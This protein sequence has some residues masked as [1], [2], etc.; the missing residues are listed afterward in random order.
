MR[1]SNWQA[2]LAI[3]FLVVWVT[4]AN[5]QSV[6]T[7]GAYLKAAS[8]EI[9]VVDSEDGVEVFVQD[10]GELRPVA[11]VETPYDVGMAVARAYPREKPF[12]PISLPM[13]GNKFRI[14]SP[15]VYD[16]EIIAIVDGFLKTEFLEGV[17]VGEVDSPIN[18]DP[19]PIDATTVA[20]WVT[21]VNDPSQAAIY[22]AELRKVNFDGDLATLKRRVREA[23]IAAFARPFVGQWRTQFFLP[24][25]SAMSAV[26]SSADYR[27]A[28][29]IVMDELAKVAANRIQSTGSAPIPQMMPVRRCDAF[30]NCTTVWVPIR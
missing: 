7:S 17:E 6:V 3:F 2:L 26:G 1:A 22:L 5:G 12:P 28:W 24:L 16:V 23:R 4:I 21:N 11:V 15:G 29:S 10:P 9:T 8:A 19:A 30:G 18:P 14:E 25:D 27:W 13:R 20:E